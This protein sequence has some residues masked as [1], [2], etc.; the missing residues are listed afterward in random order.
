MKHWYFVKYLVHW[1]GN[2]DRY[3]RIIHCEPGEIL[4]VIKEEISSNY[5]E[6]TDIV[7]LD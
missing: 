7:K 3:T 6:I 5:I 4:G 1:N 2:N